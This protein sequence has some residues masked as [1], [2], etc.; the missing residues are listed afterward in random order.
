MQKK[1]KEFEAVIEI[2]ARHA[3]LCES[4]FVRL[5]GADAVL[6]NVRDLS[7]TGEFLSDKSVTLAGAKRNLEKVSI[8]GP[9]R[10]ETQVEISRTDCF[11]LGEKNV[12]LRISGD[13]AGSAP[14]KLVGET[15]EVQLSQGL[16]IAK[17]HLHISAENAEE[18]GVS[19]GDILRLRVGG[20]RG[21]VYDN[22]IV[23]ISL[24][25]RPTVHIDTDEG[26]AIGNVSF[27]LLEK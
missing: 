16:I 25:A 13:L 1:F 2:S 9:L 12:P 24:V 6:N 7:I 11:F 4:D 19:E 10:A 18:Y 21:G 22:V 8:L 3:H 5:F 23:R 26:N 27:C 14:I 20:E 15:G 17:R